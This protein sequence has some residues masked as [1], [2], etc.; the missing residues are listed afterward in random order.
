MN[1]NSGTPF[2]GYAQLTNAAP[3][4]VNVTLYV[5]G[6]SYTP[7]TSERLYITSIVISS[8]DTAQPLVTVDS[9]GTTPTKLARAYAGAANAPPFS[10]TVAPGVGQLDFGQVPR[11]A[12]S[13]VTAT[14][15]VEVTLAGYVS[16]T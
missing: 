9:G 14:K 15:T 1:V 2:R 10:E 11:A 4:P 8:N 16:R 12:A 13:A 6:Q 7:S 3:G 5:N